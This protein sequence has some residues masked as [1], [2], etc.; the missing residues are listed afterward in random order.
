[1]MYASKNLQFNKTWSV[2]PTRIAEVMVVNTKDGKLGRNGRTP[3]VP[4]KFEVRIR[5][6][7]I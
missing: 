3:V 5:G 7:N 2:T 1:M 6:K 4:N